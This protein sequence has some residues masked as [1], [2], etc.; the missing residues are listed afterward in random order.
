[1]KKLLEQMK[2][3]LADAK[4]GK[5]IPDAD[6]TAAIALTNEDV[7]E[8]LATDGGKKLLQPTLDAYHTK[9][10]ETWKAKTLPGLVAADVEKEIQKRY[11]QET[12]VEKRL[13]QAEKSLEEEKQARVKETLRNK[14]LSTMTSKGL[15]VELADHFLGADEAG[16]LQNIA[17]LESV[18]TTTV[19]KLVDERLALGGRAP[20]QT[21]DPK[22]RLQELQGKLATATRLEEKIALRNEISALENQ[23]PAPAK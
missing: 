23:P 7:T 20:E 16:T 13:R 5:D 2:K 3:W 12:E 4:A 19:K 10:L 18:W 15:P 6:L 14:A 11:P 9:G 21:G 22:T 1:M 17:A 8:F